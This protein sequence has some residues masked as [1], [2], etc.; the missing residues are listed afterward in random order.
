[1]KIVTDMEHSNLYEV[2]LIQNDLRSEETI[3]HVVGALT[4]LSKV[5][6]DIFSKIGAK[7]EDFQQ[8]IYDVNRRVDLANLKIGALKEAKK[9]TV[10]FSSAKYPGN[11]KYPDY[12]TI[13]TGV[14]QKQ[15]YSHPKH[16]IT[17]RAQ[18]F[19]VKNLQGKLQFF[20]VKEK[21]TDRTVPN[22]LGS[23]PDNL[24]SCSSLTV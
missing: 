24:R 16:N 23:I 22:G 13:F 20:N 17:E 9:A 14:D 7:C 15:L 10:V 12:E 6:G 5:S 4:Q 21:P 3:V 19:N 18:E 8:K 1:M 2:P 11:E